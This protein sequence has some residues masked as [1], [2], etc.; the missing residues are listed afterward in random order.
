MT[1]PEL[2]PTKWEQSNPAENMKTDLV[3]MYYTGESPEEMF[4]RHLNFAKELFEYENLFWDTMTVEFLDTNWG[5]QFS[6]CIKKNKAHY[7]NN[8]PERIV[9][10]ST[11]NVKNA[12]LEVA[13]KCATLKKQIKN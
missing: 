13:K 4:Q 9:S 2:M 6:V 5:Y 11:N 12:I 3:K 1:K 10:K 8:A 7:K